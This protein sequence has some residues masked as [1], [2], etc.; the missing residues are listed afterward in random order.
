MFRKQLLLAI[1]MADLS[2]SAQTFSTLHA[3]TKT[4][5]ALSTNSDGALPGS[6][7]VLSGDTLY[8]TTDSGGQSYGTVF[9]LG[10]DGLSFTNL[11]SFAYVDGSYPYGRLLVS[12]TTLYG[13]A[14]GGGTWGEGALFK[15][16]ADGSGFTNL[17]HFTPMNGTASTNYDGASPIGALVLS[18]NLLYGISTFGGS[19]GLGVLYELDTNGNN[20]VVPLNFNNL[21]PQPSD[22]FVLSGN[23]VYAISPAATGNGAVFMINTD[24]TGYWPLHFFS[25]V[26]GIAATNLDGNSPN[27]GL[28][29]SGNLL[30][31]TTYAGGTGGNGTVFAVNTNG[32]IFTNLHSFSAT[33]SSTNFDGARPSGALVLSGNTLY[34]TTTSGG[35]AGSGTVFS[36]KTDGSGFTTLH[37][38]SARSHSTN[39]DGVYPRGGLAVAGNNVYGT[40]RNGGAS[41]NGTVFKISLPVPQ[42]NIVPAGASAIL[43]WPTNFAGFALQSAPSLTATFTNIPGATNPYTN[44]LNGTQQ[45]FRLSQ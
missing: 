22:N 40:A 13:T 7:L 15:L 29:L 3:F 38:F 41:G 43:S 9:R 32:T 8:G 17:H 28:V 2:S 10:T 33:A 11:H 21:S 16:F 4:I 12:G 1:L 30:Y 31:G 14:G 42:L 24:G 36:L 34:G 35:N 23:T 44:F 26:S 37:S 39:S 5:G 20:F 19:L 6:D 27:S 18:G 25:P 45:F